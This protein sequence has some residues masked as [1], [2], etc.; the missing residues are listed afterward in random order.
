MGF[1]DFWG[2]NNEELTIFEADLRS[3]QSSYSILSSFWLEVPSW[4]GYVF[5]APEGQVILYEETL[6]L[7]LRLLFHPFA[8]N[9][10]DFY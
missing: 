10:L 3:L 4:E 2:T 1:E 8:N 9:I 6:K 7:D 5:S